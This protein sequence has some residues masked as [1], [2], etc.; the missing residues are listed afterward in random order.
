M[1]FQPRNY[2][3]FLK[4]YEEK[5]MEAIIGLV[6]RFY[7]KKPGLAKIILAKSP[8]FEA[9][10]FS[11][12][13]EICFLSGLKKSFRLTS[14]SI[15]VTNHCNLSCPMCPTNTKMKRSKGFLD[16]ALLR[17]IIDQA[18]GLEFIFL[19]QWG[20]PFLHPGIFEFIDYASSK[21]IRTMLTTN[22][23]LCSGEMMRRVLDSGLERL[24]FSVD[25]TGATYERIRGF[26][27]D[28]IRA[29]ILKLK[30]M[31]DTKK[32]SLKIDVSMVVFEETEADIEGFRDQWRDVADGIYL[33]PRLI[34]GIRK[35]RCREMWRGN[36]TIL[37]D[38]RVVPC[39]ADFDARMIVGDVTKENISDVWNGRRMQELRTLHNRRVLPEVCSG[40]A[41]YADPRVNARFS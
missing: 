13:N 27:Y 25:G 4:K 2:L 30:K 26:S 36:L 24:T 29:N 12:M 5:A 34:P 35:N 1:D 6:A 10:F 8:S 11:L 37:W 21:S 19:F 14:L 23:T 17:R 20:E 18:P 28:R 22:G 40:C 32:S 9:G 3:S 7:L 38:G 41:E 16:A 39:C 31:R 15:E 33:I